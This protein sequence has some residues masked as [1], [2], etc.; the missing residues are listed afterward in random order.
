MDERLQRHC[1]AERML[2]RIV[3]KV[4]A[5]VLTR[6]CRPRALAPLPVIGRSERCLS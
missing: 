6:C 2:N 1:A 3:L 4:V 5:D